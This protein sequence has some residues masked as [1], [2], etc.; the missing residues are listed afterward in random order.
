MKPVPLPELQA[1]LGKLRISANPAE[2][3]QAHGR[4]QKAQP[5][6]HP[7]EQL[8]QSLAEAGLKDI[9]AAIL[10]WRR[11]DPRRLPALLWFEDEWWLAERPAPGQIALSRDGTA[12][13]ECTEDALHEAAVLWLRAP[14][15]RR[16][17]DAADE[18]SN[19]AL[20]MV[21][22]EL[23]RSRGWIPRVVVATLLVNLLAIPSSIF[24]MQV[25]DRVVP[26]LAY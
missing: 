25:Y 9:Q 24:A 7:L 13:R 5:Q 10:P 2:L 14:A 18:Q 11:L 21:W 8:R 6:A 1:L 15:R 22:Q 16:S 26:T 20:H 23:L 19:P 3:A 12:P 17:D 4:T